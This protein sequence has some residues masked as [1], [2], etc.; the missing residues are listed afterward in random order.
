MRM[1]ARNRMLPNF[2]H[3]LV[4][5]KDMRFL[6]M[7]RPSKSNIV[8]FVEELKKCDVHDVIRVCE[9]TYNSDLLIKEGINVTDWQFDDG[10]APP[11]NVVDAWL[12]LLKSRFHEHPGTTIAIHCVAGLGRAPVL[13]A[14]AL[15]EAGMKYEDAVN[16]IRKNRRGAI[17]SKQLE[18]LEKYK[19][20]KILNNKDKSGCCLQ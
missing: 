7:D 4:E 11:R 13:V 1:P 20:H 5:Y 3:C 19:P 17:N 14:I 15:I 18:Y 9:P 12:E 8:Q 6:I 16:H 10:A 2:G